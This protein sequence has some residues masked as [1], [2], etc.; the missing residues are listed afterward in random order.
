MAALSTQ[1]E[2]HTGASSAFPAHRYSQPPRPPQG[3]AGP[4]PSQ[5]AG[6]PDPP[7]P[8]RRTDPVPGVQPCNSVG[9]YIPPADPA[10]RLRTLTGWWGSCPTG[11]CQR[12]DPSPPCTTKSEHLATAP[13]LPRATHHEPPP[14][15]PRALRGAALLTPPDHFS[16]TVSLVKRP[17]STSAAG[18]RPRQRADAHP[19][20]VGKS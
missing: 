16:K 8:S 3:R 14:L 2:K 7:R 9:L 19:Y 1:Q 5:C 12:A 18:A 4:S 20:L 17:F 11:R 13:A 10:L 15:L 6:G